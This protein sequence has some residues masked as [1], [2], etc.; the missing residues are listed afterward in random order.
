MQPRCFRTFAPDCRRVPPSSSQKLRIRPTL[1][2]LED[3]CLPSTTAVTTF[4]GNPQHTAV[5]QPAAQ[6][7]SSIHWRSPVDLQPQYQS[8]GS[9]LIHYG[10]PLVTG[11]NTVIVPV[12]TGATDGFR[13]EARSGITGALKYLLSTDYTLAGL[14]F[15]WTPSYSPTLASDGAGGTRLYYAGAGGTIYY[16][17]Q[18]DSSPPG[19][20]VHEAFYGLSNYLANPAGFNSSVWIDTPM[21]PDSK[22]DIFFGFTV[23]ATAPAPLNTTQSGY[24]RIDPSGNATYVLAGNAAGDPNISRDSHNIAPALSNQEGV[25]YVV[26]KATATPTYNYL[27]GLDSTTLATRYKVFLK[28]PRSG[29]AHNATISGDG[30]ASPMLAP[31]GTVF[32]GVLGNPYNGSRGWLLHFS[33]DLSTPLTPGAFGWDQTAAIVPATMVPSYHGTSPYLIFSKYNN[34]ADPLA[35]SSEDFSDGINKIAILD[36]NAT[37]V[38]PHPSSNGLHVMREVMIVAGP[39]PDPHN[40]GPQSPN[41][42]REWCIDTAAVDPTSDCVIVPSEDGRVYR[43][44]LATGTL[45]EVI[46]VGTSIGEAYVPTIVGPDG[47]IFTI[48]NAT[49]FAIGNLNGVGVSVISSAPTSTN[50]V[51]GRPLTFTA[52]VTNTS[53]GPG[54]PT[55]T[56]TFMDGNT[57]LTQVPL[58]AVGKATFSTSTLGAGNHFILVSYNGDSHFRGGVAA[59]VQTI[60]KFATS[61][62][63]SSS[64]N[65]STLGQSV[66]FTAAVRS[67]PAGSGTPT[68]FVTFQEGTSILAQVPLNG[69]G[70]ATFSTA[71]LALGS[72]TITASYRSDPVFAASTGTDAT[73]PQVI[74]AA[75]AS[76]SALAQSIGPAKSRAL[77]GRFWLP[78]ASRTTRAYDVTGGGLRVTNLDR[79]YTSAGGPRRPSY[80]PT[81]APVLVANGDGPFESGETS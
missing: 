41:A 39:T 28:D 77:D 52:G 20:P 29:G 36:P 73:T 78:L 54:T 63:L 13:I 22:G 8:D 27:L 74:K 44:S 45:S 17:S 70:Q 5:F 72:H 67:I 50:V 7:L 15:N 2:W 65:P 47:T 34:Y 48:N 59:L 71:A 80:R 3:R 4:A 11:G 25:I 49:L 19:A 66:K 26:V 53:Q 18:P 42:V 30:T 81:K 46:N 62:A 61:I 69:T 21:T 55:G 24:A 10:A 68:G 38:D 16:I 51:V 58:N 35:P 23:Q 1:E 60:H 57:L 12:K 14:S 43:W 75:T 40:V 37:E 6:H 76:L 31:D 33:H 9:L 56:V 79:F 32:L 64:P